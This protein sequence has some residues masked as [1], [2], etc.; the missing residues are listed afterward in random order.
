MNSRQREEATLAWWRS[1]KSDDQ[2]I[3]ANMVR[4]CLLAHTDGPRTKAELH[5]YMQVLHGINIP[6]TATTPDADSPMDF[7]WALYSHEH[8]YIA[9]IASRGGG[10]TFLVSESVPIKMQYQKRISI[11]HAAAT[12]TQSEVAMSYLQSTL[13]K[14]WYNEVYD[15]K[16]TSSTKARWFNG[17]EYKIITG[18]KKGVCISGESSII[19]DQ[20]SMPIKDVVGGKKKVNVLSWNWKTDS[21]EWKPIVGWHNNGPET[22]YIRVRLKYEGVSVMPSMTPNHEVYLIDGTK[23]VAGELQ[24]GDQ[25][26]MLQPSMTPEMEQVF[27]GTMLGDAT[28]DK[29]GRL[30]FAHGQSQTAFFTWKTEVFAGWGA[31]VRDWVRG[32]GTTCNYVRF[33]TNLMTMGAR[34]EWYPE[35][36]K[37]IP[38]GV[39]DKLTELGLAVWF[40]D[41]GSFSDSEAHLYTSGFSVEENEACVEWFKS[42]GFSCVLDI[43]RGNPEIRFHASAKRKL[44]EVLSPYLTWS[45]EAGKVWVAD[46]IAATTDKVVIGNAVVGV[47]P[48][49]LKTSNK[50]DITVEDNH[51]FFLACG[52]LVSNSGQHP[53][54]QILDETEFWDIPS[55]NQ[56][57]AV[58]VSEGGRPK[59]WCA[60]STRQ[61]ATGGMAWLSDNAEEKGIKFFRWTIFETMQPC[62]T[63][64]AI[65]AHPHGTDEQRQKTCILW[66]YCHG[67]RARKASGWLTL[68]EVQ[69]NLRVLTE[70]EIET[71]YLSERPLTRGR[72]LFN[73]VEDK[74]APEGNL[75]RMVFDKSRPYLISLDP[76]EGQMAF[77]IFWQMDDEGVWNAVAE[78]CIEECSSDIQAKERLYEFIVDNNWH[79]PEALVID[80]HRTDTVMTFQSGSQVGEGAGFAWP[81]ATTPDI[82][83]KEGARF[84]DIT[85][86]LN[87]VRRYIRSGFGV[88]LAINPDTCPILLKAVKYHG[89]KLNPTTGDPTSVPATAFK[90]PIDCM[91]YGIMFIEQVYATL[92]N[93]QVNFVQV[94]S[95]PSSSIQMRHEDQILH[96]FIGTPDLE[97]YLDE[98]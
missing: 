88:Y 39:L 87:L 91:R 50:Y 75:S 89:Y 92:A 86:T 16:A 93:L 19:T 55:L 70:D 13:E 80:P 33:R 15:R 34:K 54:V 62:Q 67:T 73:F 23:K 3:A 77:F 57:F 45:R 7:F 94:A 22:N 42:K 64:I 43:R 47:E 1:L 18:T 65:D 10:K 12:R 44:L 11:R 98:V 35:R 38:A 74:Y 61:S 5:K 78:L 53:N 79:M 49:T 27:L 56:S 30:S 28:I 90:D 40:M 6:T 2:E 76:A 4:R 17:S 8:P 46:K 29:S 83:W 31:T 69:D 48:I 21:L 32:Y 26:A 37:V 36:K 66:K 51:N 14:S 9:A 84:D 71:Q 85:V 81:M 41:D 95:S 20:G 25:V 96:E 24:I 97:Q 63:C 60:V 82:K 58:P 59:L 52:M 68:Q 72:V